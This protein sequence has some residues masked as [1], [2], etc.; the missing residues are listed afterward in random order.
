MLNSYKISL[1]FFKNIH[2]QSV[3]PAI[4]SVVSL[5]RDNIGPGTGQVLKLCL[6][7]PP[8]ALPSLYPAPYPSACALSQCVLPGFDFVHLVTFHSPYTGPLRHFERV[9]MPLPGGFCVASAC[10]L[11]E[12]VAVARLPQASGSVLCSAL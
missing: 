12:A 3:L 8:M 1:N 4:G 5:K 10:G 6:A 11:P 9:G 7:H 2:L